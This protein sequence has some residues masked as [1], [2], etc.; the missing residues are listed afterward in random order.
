[1][2]YNFKIKKRGVMLQQDLNIKI[3]SSNGQI[4][5]G[6]EYAGSQ[7][8]IIKQDDDTL[9]IKKGKFIP[10]NERW[11]YEGDNL[12]RLEKAIK[13]A[14]SRERINNSEELLAKFERIIEND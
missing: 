11:L 1:M 8:Q 4:S 12:E 6:K 13:S 9:L 10:N 3:V 2:F 14:E 5:I 7:V